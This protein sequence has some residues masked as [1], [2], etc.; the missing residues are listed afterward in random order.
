MPFDLQAHRGGIALT[1]ENTLPAF[2]RALEVG[3]STLEFDAQITAD[4]H[5]VVCHDADP[6]PER[7]RDTGPAFAGDP[8]YPYVHQERFVRDLTLAQ[9]RTIDVGSVHHPRYPDQ[10]LAPGARMPLLTEVFDLVRRHQAD[11]VRFNIEL[12]VAADRP[13]ASATAA[14]FVDVVVSTLRA[15]GM[16]E[17]ATLQSFD[18]VALERV[19][20][21]EPTL[22]TY[23]LSGEKYLQ[24]GRAGASPWLGGL[25]VD[26]FSG[27]LQ[28]RY[29]A[30]AAAIGAAAVSPVHGA[31]YWGGVSDPAYEPFTTVELVTAAHGEGMKVVPYIVNDRATMESLIDIGVDGFITDR[32]DL[33]R[34]VMTARSL[35]LPP[36]AP[37]AGG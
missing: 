34:E 16:L 14:Q 18:W 27:S 11:H 4:G 32:P 37:A 9:V 13:A 8:A 3:V 24:P 1:V 28:Q 5:A 29:V 36:R 22:S 20:A 19:R 30:A 10:Q 21:V 31:P 12:K 26:D 17:R 7:C 2:A 23:A 33:G 6:T 35:L 15:S 25:D